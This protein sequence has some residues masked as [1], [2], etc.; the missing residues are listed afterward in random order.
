ML[1]FEGALSHR[2]GIPLRECYESR[3]TL[4]CKFKTPGTWR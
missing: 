4:A 2:V 3:L 1:V